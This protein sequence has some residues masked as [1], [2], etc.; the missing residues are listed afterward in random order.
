MKKRLDKS[1]FSLREKKFLTFGFLVQFA[2][3]AIFWGFL[4]SF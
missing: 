2:D 1:F 4:E 3:F